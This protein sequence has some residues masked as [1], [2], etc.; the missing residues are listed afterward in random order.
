MRVV[1]LQSPKASAVAANNMPLFRLV[2]SLFT[3][4]RFSAAAYASAFAA[5]GA[6]RPRVLI[7]GTGWGGNTL[8]RALDK[9][10]F[11]VRVVSPSNHFL[12]TPFLPATAVGT[13]EFRSI[14]EC[15]RSTPGLEEYYQA[16][17]RRIDFAARKVQCED[18]FHTHARFHVGYD[19]LCIAAGCKT[20]TFNTPGVAEREGREVFFLKHLFHAR[21]IRN[22]AL[23]CFER[24]ANPT[25]SRDERNRLLSFVIVGGGPTS[26]EFATE[27]TDFLRE[28]VARAYGGRR[29]SIRHHPAPQSRPDAALYDGARTIFIGTRTSRR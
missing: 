19:F 10:K 17:A 3:S 13:L 20:N 2:R 15:I 5:T 22:R 21:A 6:T 11:D 28:D 27:L 1:Q 24:A 7:L 25:L 29:T 9:S 18:V 4:R 26:C 23:E 14:Q 16:K 8:A 12:F